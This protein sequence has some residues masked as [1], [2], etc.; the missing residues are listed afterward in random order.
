ME[1]MDPDPRPPFPRCWDSSGLGAPKALAR[2]SLDANQTADKPLPA[3]QI[4]RSARDGS[5][6]GP[7]TTRAKSE[8]SVANWKR[9]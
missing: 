4:R 6:S 8:Q 2:H 1:T 3:R 7:C 9:K 5:Q